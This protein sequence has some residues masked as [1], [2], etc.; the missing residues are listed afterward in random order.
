MGPEP[1]PHHSRRFSSVI[2]AGAF[3]A[4][5]AA[6]HVRVIRSNGFTAKQPTCFGKACGDP[7]Q[8]LQRQFLISFHWFDISLENVVLDAWAPPLK[9]RSQLDDGRNFPIG[10]P[11]TQP[12]GRRCDSPAAV[13]R[14]PSR[15]TPLSPPTAPPPLRFSSQKTNCFQNKQ[16]AC[17]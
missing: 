1:T 12:L 10:S 17:C 4:R 11:G 9:R 8:P 15:R 16:V 13:V 5:C 6:R 2:V 7:C 3:A 14:Q